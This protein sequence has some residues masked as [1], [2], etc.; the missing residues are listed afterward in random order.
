MKVLG[1]WFRFEWQHRGSPHVHG[2]AWFEDAPDVEELLATSEIS[3]MASQDN[4]ELFSAAEEMNG[5]S[6]MHV[7][8]Q[9][10]KPDIV[11]ASDASGGWQY[12]RHGGCNSNGQGRSILP[13]RSWYQW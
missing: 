7:Y 4:S 9:G 5:K 12:G 3:E 10:A 13:L 6:F 8:G 11:V 1:Y 2:L